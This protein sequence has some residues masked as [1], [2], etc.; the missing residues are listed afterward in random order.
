M[1]VDDCSW[2][3]APAAES[4]TGTAT[5]DSL[6]GPSVMRALHCAGM[7]AWKGSIAVAIGLCAAAAAPGCLSL[8]A[9]DHNGQVV[10]LPLR[11]DCVVASG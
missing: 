3:S 11:S 4:E 6:T 2:L 8:A 10:L 9:V 5:L 7:I 1:I